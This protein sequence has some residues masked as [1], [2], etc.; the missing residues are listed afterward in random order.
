MTSESAAAVSS[1]WIDQGRVLSGAMHYFRIHPALWSDR[2]QRLAALGVGHVETYVPWNFHERVRGEIDFDGWR[3]LPR[4]I[5]LAEEHG[6]DVIVRPGP[7]ICAEWDNGGLPTWLTYDGPIPLRTS[8]PRFLG[9][10]DAWFDLLIPVLAPL[11]RTQG[12]PIV[13]M[14][15][16][17]EYGS[18]GSDRAYLEHLRDGLRS[19]GVA[20]PLFTS[21]GPTDLMLDAGTLP[22]VDATA[23]FGS[24]AADAM[25]VLAR[26]RPG[27]AFFCAEF[28]GGWFD[29]WGHRH[30]TRAAADVGAAVEPL[31][32]GGGSINVYMAHGGTS[33][34]TWPGANIDEGAYLPT[35][36]S[37][38][39]DAPI[40]EA[41]E[42]R[43]KFWAL[44][45]LF[46]S[47]TGAALPVPPPAPIRQASRTASLVPG[48]ALLSALRTVSDRAVPSLLPLTQEQL[49]QPAG[50]T[51]YEA[52]L[53]IPAG[54]SVLRV[55]EPR[56]RAWVFLD[57][58]LVHRVDRN[59]PDE[60]VPLSGE[61]TTGRLSVVVE[62]EGRVNFGRHVG[63]AKG[64]LGGASID[65][66]GVS[67][68]VHGWVQRP[69]DVQ[70]LTELPE[71]PPMAGSS[72]PGAFRAELDCG[73]PADAFLALPGW[74]KVY[75][76]LNGFLLG[77]LDARGP[78]RTLYAPGPLWLDGRNLIE[79]LSLGRAGGDLEVV[80]QPDLGVEGH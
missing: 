61:G 19:R 56:D 73:E 80:D 55:L 18:F 46:G 3:D 60:G 47:V 31:L 59:V 36:T 57:G 11:Q 62:N 28:W 74:E 26:R 23:N 69:V 76:W 7:F 44:R 50:L 48:S 52:D 10:V 40:G 77:R 6:L 8:D 51:L 2:L 45:D 27:Q 71:L 4:F 63:E 66:H 42:L 39:S 24:A 12:G 41:G 38:D 58:E 34:G 30:H 35:V 22:D 16:E 68:L 14:Q 72:A 17:N 75:V 70:V 5:R 65:A 79:V 54:D 21:D 29:H 1:G 9:P 32:H 49:R 37:Y 64:L 78:Q 13:S 25:R 43:E 33:F 53:Q 20:V 67:R 15:V